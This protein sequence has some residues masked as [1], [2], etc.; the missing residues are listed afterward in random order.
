M[1]KKVAIQV[2]KIF[3][4][5]LSL[6]E[7]HFGQFLVGIQNNEIDAERWDRL[8]EEIKTNNL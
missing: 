5:K 8:F 6:P 7:N 2:S 4:Q 3:W 1:S